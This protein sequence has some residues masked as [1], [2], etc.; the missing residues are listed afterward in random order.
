MHQTLSLGVAS[1]A[2]EMVLA[3][4]HPLV[5]RSVVL[6]ATRPSTPTSTPTSIPRVLQAAEA[7][8][9]HV[10]AWMTAAAQAREG[11]DGYSTESTLTTSSKNHCP[12]LSA[13]RFVVRLGCKSPPIVAG[14]F[15]GAGFAAETSMMRALA[16]AAQG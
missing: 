12:A 4:A 5:R 8:E 10:S 6:D 11:T 14:A 2:A 1:N 3:V 7:E 13:S 16:L 15:G 9:L